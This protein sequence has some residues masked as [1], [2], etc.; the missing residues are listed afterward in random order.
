MTSKQL[1]EHGRPRRLLLHKHVRLKDDIDRNV[2]SLLVRIFHNKIR[3]L[4]TLH[5]MKIN[6]FRT[7]VL[8]SVENTFNHLIRWLFVRVEDRR[9]QLQPRWE[10]FRVF[11]K[12]RSLSRFGVL[13]VPTRS[14]VCF[15]W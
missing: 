14:R 2:C 8:T 13:V 4:G 6:H 5:R 12:V 1:N 7:V 3:I 15:I 10:I 9:Y 11:D